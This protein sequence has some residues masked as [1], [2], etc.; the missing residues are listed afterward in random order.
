MKKLTL[1][2]QDCTLSDSL[3][4]PIPFQLAE[5]LDDTGDK[6]IEA[7]CAQRLCR[8]NGY[9]PIDSSPGA[10]WYSRSSARSD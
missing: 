4:L 7:E 6:R 8:P 10:S 1:Q 3:S 2:D 5:L 9:Y